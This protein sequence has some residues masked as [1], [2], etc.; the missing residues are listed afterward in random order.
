MSCK[1]PE[2]WNTPK[3]EKEKVLLQTTH[4]TL[5]RSPA[6][7]NSDSS[8]C[9]KQE[10]GEGPRGEVRDKHWK[11]KIKELSRISQRNEDLSTRA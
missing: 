3:G 5:G 11:A 10:E 2:V 8:S 1:L 6:E 7:V 4:Q 9:E